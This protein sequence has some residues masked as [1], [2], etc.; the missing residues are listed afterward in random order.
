MSLAPGQKVSL[1]ELLLG[2]ATFS[3]NDAATAVAL[4]FARTVKD[5]TEMMDA[6]AAALGL[7]KTRFADASGYRS[8]SLTT[9]REFAEFCRFYINTHPESLKDYHSV[10]EFSY[11]RAENVAEQY[12]QN[13][14]TRTQRNR[15]TL[16]GRVDGVDGLKTGYIVESGYN[17]AITAERRGTRFI[18]VIL[19]APSGWG[20]DRIRDVDAEKLLDW[21]FERYRTIRPDI[22][23]LEPVRIWKGREN[24]TDIII[25]APLEFTALAERGEQLS[26]SI[27]IDY[28]LI[29]PL[30]AG[31]HAGTLVLFDNL[32]DLRRIP[33]VTAQDAESGGFFKR[34]L[35][36]IRLFFQNNFRFII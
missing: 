17:I 15:N 36:S 25:N 3:G 12:A 9:A 35:D 10:M 22:G 18:A 31:T 6:E 7:I 32:G 1:R 2:M 19:G 24:Y 13:P 20:G 34:L 16:L 33:L 5:F 30:P 28:P 8:A 14:R 27:N 4:R 11:P 26:W 23:E 29:A 21:A